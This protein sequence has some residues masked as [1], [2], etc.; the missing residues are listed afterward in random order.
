MV[1]IG[2]HFRRR[3]SFTIAADVRGDLLPRTERLIFATGVI[4]A[5]R[6]RR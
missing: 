4:N 3:S 5:R 2:E 6:A 1:F